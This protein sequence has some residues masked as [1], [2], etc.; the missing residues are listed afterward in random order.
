MKKIIMFGAVSVVTMAIGTT[1]FASCHFSENMRNVEG[2][3]RRTETCVVFDESAEEYLCI[4]TDEDQ[5]GICDNCYGGHMHENPHHNSYYDGNVSERGE[6]GMH[7]SE[8][9]HSEKH[10]LGHH[11]R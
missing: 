2:N 3:D 6:S 1:G 5:D 7:H 10:A 8:R 11:H 9:H 4:F